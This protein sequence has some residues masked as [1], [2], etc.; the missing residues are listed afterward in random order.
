MNV[1][2]DGHQDADLHDAFEAML[3]DADE[4]RF[5][6]V[7]DAA[8]A[9]G[10]R[11]RRRRRMA[12]SAAGA[13]VAV[14]VLAV[15]TAVGLPERAPDSPADPPA[16]TSTPS[17]PDSPVPTPSRPSMDVTGP[18]DMPSLETPTSAGTTGSEWPENETT[19]GQPSETPES[20]LRPD[21][22]GPSSS[23]W[24]PDPSS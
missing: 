10:R 12:A 1:H 2:Q 16:P 3:A 24:S 6:S 20:P 22:E 13:V 21:P 8:V 19:A 11:M 23:S 17:V 4:P 5:P 15:T 14:G 7:T 9:G 18:T